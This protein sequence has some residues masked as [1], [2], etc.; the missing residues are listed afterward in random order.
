MQTKCG[1]KF[2]DGVNRLLCIPWNVLVPVAQRRNMPTLD[3]VFDKRGVA[4]VVEKLSIEVGFANFIVLAEKQLSSCLFLWN[5]M[6][7]M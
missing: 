6:K 5:E 1:D 3:P 2:G 4:L 7:E